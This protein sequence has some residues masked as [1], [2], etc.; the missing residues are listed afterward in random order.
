M[1][2]ED[3][4]APNQRTR[5][6]PSNR[7]ILF[8]GMPHNH[9]GINVEPLDNI[10]EMER[11]R[12]RQSSKERTGSDNYTTHATGASGGELEECLSASHKRIPRTEDNADLDPT[13]HMTRT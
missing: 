1:N 2:R 6:V 5:C 8:L 12:C 9:E 13:E 4:K 10:K 3:I 11:G 7:F